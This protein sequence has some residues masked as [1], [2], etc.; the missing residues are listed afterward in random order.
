MFAL[1]HRKKI[2]RKKTAPRRLSFEVLEDRTLLSPMVIATIPFGSSR[3]SSLVTDAGLQR[4]FVAEE[5]NHRIAVVDAAS[6]AVLTTVPTAGFHTGMDVDPVEHRV[7]V[8]QQFAGRVLAIDGVTASVVTDLPIPG[9]IHTIGDVAVNPA[10]HRLY[11]VRANNNDVA[12]M[13]LTTNSFVGAVAIPAPVGQDLIDLAVDA[14]SNRIYATN[15]HSDLTVIDGASNTVLLTVPLGSDSVRFV[16]IHP[17]NHRL[18]ITNTDANT[19]T[20]LDGAPGSPTEYSV[21]A[22]IPVETSPIGVAVNPVTGR[23]YVANHDRNTVSVIDGA[24]NAV[25]AT[26]PVSSGPA[27]IGLV[28]GLS[29][30]Y[31]GHETGHAVTVIE[32]TDGSAGKCLNQAPTADAG[33]PYTITYGDSLTLDASGSSDPDGDALNYS[34]TINGNALAASGSPTL[35]LT[36]SDLQALGVSAA[37]TYDVSVSVDDGHGLNDTSSATVTIDQKHISGS[38]TAANK[39]YDG[40]TSATVLTRSL[41]GAIGGDDVSLTGGTATFDTKDAGTAKT[42]TLTG[43][44]LAGADAGNYVLDGVS[45]TTANITQATLTADAAT[46]AALNISKAGTID[47]ALTNL[48]GIVDAQTVAQL[49]NGATFS[50]TIG[51]KAY[52]VTAIAA[53]SADGTI[54]IGWR[55]TK[56]L[57]DDLIAVLGTSSDVKQTLALPLDLK[58]SADSNDG[59]YQLD[60]DAITKLFMQGKLTFV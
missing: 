37:G 40:N 25:V 38:F 11:V 13:D 20:V 34:W 26:V 39:V 8:A 60:A 59:N 47:M 1:F 21:L 51:A 43:A 14:G 35:A 5:D 32:D 50:L 19:V 4:V 52:S 15:R 30:I 10:T 9:L 23:I 2:H 12:V 27:S 49:F 16:A 28:P 17:G 54:N 45:T 31:V 44:S 56:E 24:T 6:N 41:S 53:V 36:R 7:Y 22:T 29:R 57:Q 58:V 46:Q 18:Y 55:M 42:V 3:A 48:G 33:G